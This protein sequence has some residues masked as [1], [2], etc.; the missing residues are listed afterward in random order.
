MVIMRTTNKFKDGTKKRLDY[1][2]CGNW[3]NKGS[4]VCHSNTIRCDKANE[5]VFSKISGV[6]SNEKM[7]KLIVSNVNNERKGRVNP[8]KMKIEKN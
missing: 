8:A 5:Y 6:L 7:I 2:A 4:S 1:Y 3:E